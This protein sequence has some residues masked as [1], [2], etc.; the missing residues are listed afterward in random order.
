MKPLCKARQKGMRIL[1]LIVALCIAPT[2]SNARDFAQRLGP[3]QS[4]VRF[5]GEPV[6]FGPQPVSTIDP[7]KLGD[8]KRGSRKLSVTIEPHLSIGSGPGGEQ[9]S[10]GALLRFEATG[11]SPED[12]AWFLFAGTKGQAVSWDMDSTSFDLDDFAQLKQ[13]QTIGDFQIGLGYQLAGAQV[14]LGVTR[15]TYKIDTNTRSI[16]DWKSRQTAVGVSVAWRP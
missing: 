14:S 10:G 11:G 4:G 7:I 3:V 8:M 2:V 13:R 5:I 1:A 6:S 16:G 15:Q 9:R 12:G